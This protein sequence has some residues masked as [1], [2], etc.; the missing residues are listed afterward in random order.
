MAG[1]TLTADIVVL[2]KRPAADAF[3]LLSLFSAEH[4]VLA[5]LQRIP[6][7]SASTITVLDL[8]DEASVVLET[9]NQGQTWFFKEARLL[10]RPI[11]ISRNYE[12]LLLAS[13]FTALVARNNAPE[14]SRGSVHTLLRQSLAAFAGTSRP[15][16]VYLKSIYLYVRDEGYPLKQHWVPTLPAS[17]RV[18]LAELLNQPVA[19]QTAAPPL[20]ARLQR[21]LDDYLRAHTEIMME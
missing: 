8:F 5:A 14:E 16:V 7:K 9:G 21:R 15:D 19:A 1:P 6:K 4:G 20:V 18:A 11:D 3:Q 13:T 12:A 17:D 2:L 10:Q